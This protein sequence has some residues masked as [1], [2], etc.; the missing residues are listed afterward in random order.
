MCVKLFRT[1][2]VI[3]AP[4]VTLIT[5]TNVPH[6]ENISYFGDG[7]ETHM[8]Y[9]FSLP[10]LLLHALLS[11]NSQFLTDWLSSLEP[12]PEGCN[13]F[14]FTSSHDGIGVRPLDGLVPDE[15][16]TA[17]AEGDKK[18]GG[19]VSY[20]KNFDKTMSLNELIII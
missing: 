14:N 2:E 10:P 15:E 8:V 18:K 16:L 7:D 19:F 13:Y 4:D 1:M 3:D 6:K 5:E 20:N 9:Q 11:E 17:L 12:L